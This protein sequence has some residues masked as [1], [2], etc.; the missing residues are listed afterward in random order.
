[1]S[2]LNWT[3][4]PWPGTDLEVL[5]DI[6]IYIPSIGN[7]TIQAQKCATVINNLASL[8]Q[9]ENLTA[10]N[11]SI[12]TLFGTTVEQVNL[13]QEVL[14]G[15]DVMEELVLWGSNTLKGVGKE[16]VMSSIMGLIVVLLL[17]SCG[18][19][20]LRIWS[21]YKIGGKERLGWSEWTLIA[22][23]ICSIGIA[24]QFGGNVMN[25]THQGTSTIYFITYDS[26]ILTQIHATVE[27]IM[28]HAAV[29][30]IKSSV[31]IFY[32]TLPGQPA[33]LRYTTILIFF[34][35][36][37]TNIAGFFF[38]I[39][40]CSPVAYWYYELTAICVDYTLPI[41]VLGIAN[42]ACDI[43]IWLMP[44]AMVWRIVHNWRARS[45]AA[46][47][48]TAAAGA[49]IA[50]AFRCHLLWAEKWEV[51]N[52]NL[53]DFSISI[54]TAVEVNV[55]VVCYNIP[56]IRSLVIYHLERRKRFRDSPVS[57][58]TTPEMANATP[59][60]EGI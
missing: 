6:S 56:A 23:V 2:S 18:T 44:M 27:Q 47:T 17:L 28:Y 60:I 7:S 52:G 3:T 13:L 30:L 55:M 42:I 22:G 25:L 40:S 38:N 41:F 32:Y 31:L 9:S 51:S 1:M 20:M 12:A 35:N 16:G 34:I 50:S 58:P 59:H 53:G 14:G 33:F 8:Y 10:S 26:Y 11:A 4:D 45:L 15:A 46:I 5:E 43:V 36:A 39:F 24:S 48:I 49:C 21:R 29:G 54:C 57:Q 19:T 37:A